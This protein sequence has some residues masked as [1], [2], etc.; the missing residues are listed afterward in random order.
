M[1]SPMAPVAGFFADRTSAIPLRLL[2]SFEAHYFAAQMNIDD[3]NS[4]QAIKKWLLRFILYGLAGRY[5]LAPTPVSS[6]KSSFHEA[7]K[8]RFV[9]VAMK[10]HISYIPFDSSIRCVYRNS[11]TEQI[12]SHSQLV[13]ALRCDIKR[14][15]ASLN[16][17]N[18]PFVLSQS[19]P[20]YLI[21]A[22]S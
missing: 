15:S 11:A 2:G 1:R 21:M 22:E 4:S 10:R 7:R 19:I 5:F 14:C 12:I 18:M 17:R 8:T 13:A 20:R 6:P 9:A 3:K 16:R